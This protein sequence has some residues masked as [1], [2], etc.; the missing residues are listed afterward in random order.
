MRASVREEGV[1]WS[2]TTLTRNLAKW[3]ALF[4]PLG[5]WGVCVIFSTC[6]DVAATA[7]TC[8]HQQLIALVCNSKRQRFLVVALITNQLL[9]F[10]C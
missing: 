2:T 10:F 8:R 5:G 7:A 9:G 4:G 6:A 1:G 3:S